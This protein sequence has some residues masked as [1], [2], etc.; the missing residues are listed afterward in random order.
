VARSFK[1]TPLE[2]P[3][4]AWFADKNMDPDVRAADRPRVLTLN[5]D[6]NVALA[7]RI[8]GDAAEPAALRQ[9][10]AEALAEANSRRARTAID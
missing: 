1:L 10:T 7:G 3:L 2:A 4:A 8:C 6:A 5:P 9:K